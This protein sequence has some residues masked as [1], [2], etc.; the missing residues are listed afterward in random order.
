MQTYDQKHIQDVTEEMTRISKADGHC[1]TRFWTTVKLVSVVGAFVRVG[2][3]NLSAIRSCRL[4]QR[5]GATFAAD[6]H[7]A[8]RADG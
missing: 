4:R 7:R 2:S 5:R 1:L 8:A 3:S 6:G